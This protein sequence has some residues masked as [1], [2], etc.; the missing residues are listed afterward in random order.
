[1]PAT[2]TIDDVLYEQ[3]LG[4]T[5]P[6]MDKTGCSMRRSAP[7]PAFRLAGA[8]QRRAE[9]RRIWRTV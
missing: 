1:M 2:A 6:G 5:D 8:L 7:L 9:S 4:V 3:A